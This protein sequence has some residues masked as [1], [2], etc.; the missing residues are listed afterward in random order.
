[1][2]TFSALF[3]RFLSTALFTFLLSLGA[4]LTFSSAFGLSIRLPFLIGAAAL[5]SVL[6]AL[7]YLLERPW[8]LSLIFFV[9]FV[10]V[11]FHQFNNIMDGAHFIHQRVMEIYAK[12]YS[13]LDSLIPDYMRLKDDY[14]SLSLAVPMVVL[15]FAGASSINHR[16][17]AGITVLLSLPWLMV[18]LVAQDT[19]PKTI[20]LLMLSLSYIYLLFASTQPFRDGGFPVFRLL[21]ILPAALFIILIG[22]LTRPNDYKE[23]AW[24]ARIR[25]FSENITSSLPGPGKGN[26]Y[27]TL[28]N[29]P[30]NND[31]SKIDLKEV[32]PQ[33][34]DTEHVMDV[35]DTESRWIYLKACSYT[36]YSSDGW[37]GEPF[38]VG[39]YHPDASVWY[40]KKASTLN[41][42]TV[43][44]DK[45]AS[46]IYTL[47]RLTDLPNGAS[48]VS[49]LR[50]NNRWYLR[51]YPLPM[52]QETVPV[53]KEYINY[54]RNI[55]TRLSYTET[56]LI[57][58]Y[59]S[60]LYAN[61]GG[62]FVVR[63]DSDVGSFSSTIQIDPQ[64][65]MYSGHGKSYLAGIFDA[66]AEE[67]NSDEENSEKG[68]NVREIAHYVAS[69]LQ[70]DKQYDLSTPYMPEGEDFVRWFLEKSPTGYCI[71][72]AS[73]ATVLLRY[74]D[75][76]ARLCTG[77]IIET[78]ADNTVEVTQNMA[79]A[80]V[81]Y[82]DEDRGWVTLEVTPGIFEEDQTPASGGERE[83][84][85]WSSRPTETY[86]EN[87]Q[88]SG[89]TSAA[90]KAEPQ[91]GEKAPAIIINKYVLISLLIFL[92]AGLPLLVRFLIN[93]YLKGG[94]PK[95]SVL[96]HY[97]RMNFFHRLSRF[98]MPEEAEAL[99]MKARF[100]NHE[101]TE[102]DQ[103][104]M[105]QHYR[106]YTIK[107]KSA[108]PRIRAWLFRILF[109]L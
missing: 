90:T 102:E 66:I 93:R 24:A 105:M 20:P 72:F 64:A 56:E 40:N 76:P 42:V 52:G 3:S 34:D 108:Y 4:V 41:T 14:V 103:R 22:F 28:G 21:L 95:E 36:D 87:N 8:I 47:S 53:T 33:G 65:V 38:S 50:L 96:R 27:S 74:M 2:K 11:F 109:L 97:R 58:Q 39:G 19:Y 99:A 104:E 46:V 17:P 92:L 83:T 107:L 16:L 61:A 81:E 59:L 51:R 18:C 60:D 5:L 98:S 23:T 26:Y 89:N 1:M 57:H 35:S 63:M 75:I 30:W 32:G 25:A 37:I 45:T 29:Q 48:P 77:Y 71:H 54:V 79:H 67:E 62:S 44:A 10:L 101:I 100:S 31:T 69:F 88:A 43:S 49:D 7:P 55:Y 86:S 106:Y 84:I 78:E 12:T 82:F 94:S 70:L 80:W 6:T 91:D 73:A 85:D 68:Y 13:R 9:L 15:S